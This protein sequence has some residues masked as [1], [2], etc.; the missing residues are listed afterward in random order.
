MYRRFFLFC[1]Q[2][3]RQMTKQHGVAVTS[4]QNEYFPLPLPLCSLGQGLPQF[5]KPTQ[6]LLPY[7]PPGG[8]KPTDTPLLKCTHCTEMF[9]TPVQLQSHMIGH[10]EMALR[11]LPASAFSGDGRGGDMPTVIKTEKD[12]NG[13]PDQFMNRKD[14]GW[15]DMSTHPAAATKSGGGHL[16]QPVSMETDGQLPTTSEQNVNS[17][18]KPQKPKAEK[19]HECATCHK[20]FTRTDHL[21]RHA[22][23]SHPEVM[24]AGSSAMAACTP[25]H[26]GLIRNDP[27]QILAKKNEGQ[28]QCFICGKRFKRTDHLKRHMGKSHA[29]LLPTESSRSL[30]MRFDIRAMYGD[31]GPPPKPAKPRPPPVVPVYT[32]SEKLEKRHVCITCEK[33]FKRQDHLKRHMTIHSEEKPY[34]CVL[35][36]KGFRREHHVQRHERT[37]TGEKPYECVTCGKKFARIDHMKKHNKSH[38]FDGIRKPGQ[39]LNPALPSLNV[40]VSQPMCEEIPNIS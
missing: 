21:K 30:L 25:Q 14:M 11:S 10:Y 39:K 16:G 4:G 20:R 2:T 34:N 24:A 13:H 15:K 31:A 36:G 5:P 40:P 23:K 19:K 7:L 32:E 6:G 22:M 8:F 18:P 33:R 3:I 27:T 12:A 17:T 9:A 28:H 29:D 35:C 38:L 1:W 26:L 37:H